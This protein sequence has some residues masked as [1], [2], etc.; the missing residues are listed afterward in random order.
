MV[1]QEDRVCLEQALLPGDVLADEE[2]ETGG[3]LGGR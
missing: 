1:L 3:T 2:A